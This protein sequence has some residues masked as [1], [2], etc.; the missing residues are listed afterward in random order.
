VV[1]GPK[2]GVMTGSAQ[3]VPAEPGKF[4]LRALDPKTGEK[5][6]EYPMTGPALMWAGTMSTAGGLVFFGDDDGQLVA[7]DAESGKNLWHYSMGQ[8]LTASPMTFSVDGNQYV[9]IAA[10]SDVYTFGLFA[11]A[12][13]VPLV[14]TRGE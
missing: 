4:F 8:P 13:P 1:V 10:G 11:P 5:R 12:V 2:K 14:P 3:D 9:S 6:W 7:L